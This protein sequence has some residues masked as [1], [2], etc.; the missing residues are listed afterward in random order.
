MKLQVYRT[1]SSSYQDSQ[2]VIKEKRTLEKIKGVK[3]VQN[4]GEVEPNV[5][6]VLITNTDTK[7]Q[8]IAKSIVSKTALLIHPNSGHDNISLDFVKSHNFPIVLGNPIRANAVCEYALSCLFHHFTKIPHQR[9]WSQSRQWSRKLLR[10]QKVLILGYGHIGKILHQSLSPLCREVKV[11][12]P[13]SR[14]NY[15]LENKWDESLF[16]DVSVLLVAAS[17]NPTSHH[18]INHNL[19]K[20]LAQENIIIN[21][22]RGEIIKEVELVQYL[23]KNPRSF[24][25]LDV[26]EKE[27]FP[28]GHLNE[29]SNLNKTSHIAGNHDRINSDIISFEYI[30]INDFMTHFLNNTLSSFNDEYK[31]CLLTESGFIK[32]E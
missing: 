6:F 11:Y 27:P 5:P 12:D 29:L 31:E 16:D 19:L 1:A 32:D 22:S 14:A 21:I 23:Q 9:H 30:V 10:E 24:C 7:P 3:Y 25:Y 2:F 18:M 8:Q 26:F 4:L 20:K 13:F 17:L 28:P 15:F